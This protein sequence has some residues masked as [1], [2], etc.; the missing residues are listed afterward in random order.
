MSV[1]I[2][3]PGDYDMM[4]LSI[5]GHNGYTMKLEATY[6]LVEIY[7]DIFGDSITAT[8]SIVT[9]QDLIDALPIIGQETVRI[10]V[11]HP[12]DTRLPIEL[13]MVVYKLTDFSVD[14]GT[15]SFTLH[16]VTPEQITNYETRISR[17]FEGAASD[18]VQELYNTLGSQRGLIKSS[19]EDNQKL[20]VPG[21]TPMKAINWMATKAFRQGAA[22]FLF[23]EDVQGHNFQSLSELTN[24]EPQF[25]YKYGIPNVTL[26]AN[27]EDKNIITFKF[28]SHFNVMQNMIKSMYGGK[29]KLIDIINKN[30]TGIEYNIYDQYNSVDRI[31]SQPL[32][33]ISGQGKQFHPDS[34][35]LLPENTDMTYNYEQTFLRRKAQLQLF[36]NLKLVFTAFGDTQVNAGKLIDI[37]FPSFVFGSAGAENPKISGNWLVTAVKHTFSPKNGYLSSVE[38]V[39]DSQGDPYPQ[40]QPIKTGLPYYDY[41]STGAF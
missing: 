27:T 37:T 40:P 34:L 12:G 4:E 9:T 10:K 20:I 11:N 26:D 28:E 1:G 32:F 25:F 24:A 13:N 17:A 18:I 7:E 38:C 36:D 35:F 6:T 8:I 30:V 21:M 5:T 39:R 22:D 29:A 31:E 19:S 16:L 2:T 41:D 14:Q 15:T 23:W 33:D 3:K